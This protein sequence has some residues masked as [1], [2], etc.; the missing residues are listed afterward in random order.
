MK[1]P[2][3]APLDNLI[4][5]KHCPFCGNKAVLFKDHFGQFRVDCSTA[6]REHRC[7]FARING[8]SI[9]RFETPDHAAA[10]WNRRTE[11]VISK[12]DDLTTCLIK[13]D[14]KND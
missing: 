8:G 9:P 6:I 5:L 14:A 7:W 3:A 10:F 2:A 4:E 11:P 1:E 13:D 12:S